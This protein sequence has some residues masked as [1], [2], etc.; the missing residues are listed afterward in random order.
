MRRCQRW[1]RLADIPPHQP[2]R[3]CQP[4]EHC[5][6]RMGAAGLIGHIVNVN[7]CIDINIAV[8][9]QIYEWDQREKW[10]CDHFGIQLKFYTA[11]EAHVT[12]DC[13]YLK[14]VPHVGGVCMCC[15]WQGCMAGPMSM[16]P[17]RCCSRRAHAAWERGT[18]AARAL[19]LSRGL[20]EIWQCGLVSKDPLCHPTVRIF[21]QKHPN[22]SSTQ[23]LPCLNAPLQ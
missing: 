6:A 19:E 21:V 22:F 7:E 8:R 3:R 16:L 17:V 11:Y 2:C 15:A 10:L 1:L 13:A 5:L 23:Y 20:R 9:I 18:W 12:T 14:Y 4:G